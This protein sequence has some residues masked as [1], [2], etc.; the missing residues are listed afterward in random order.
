MADVN[1][2]KYKF[3]DSYSGVP[4]GIFNGAAGGYHFGGGWDA[5]TDRR[6]SKRAE[7]LQLFKDYV[8]TLT[9]NGIVPNQNSLNNFLGQASGFGLDASYGFDPY[10]AQQMMESAIAQGEQKK[11][12]IQAKN[13]QTKLENAKRIREDLK[14]LVGQ[15]GS[16]EDALKKRVSTRYEGWS[17]EEVNDYTA[18]ATQ[19]YLEDTSKNLNTL[20]GDSVDEDQFDELKKQYKGAPPAVLAAIDNKYNANVEAASNNIATNLAPTLANVTD[21]ET[22][23]KMVSAQAPE[24][25]KNN[26]QFIENTLKKIEGRS[27]NFKGQLHQS[28]AEDIAKN[29]HNINQKYAELKAAEEDKIRAAQAALEARQKSDAI[30]RSKNKEKEKEL[31]KGEKN[32]TKKA[33]AESKIDAKW[34]YDIHDAEI[35]EKI[36]NAEDISEVHQAIQEGLKNG[37]VFTQAELD[38]IEQRELLAK[39]KSKDF[40]T[41]DKGYDYKQ[42][43]RIRMPL[44][45]R[46]LGGLKTASDKRKG[47][48]LSDDFQLNKAAELIS[49]DIGEWRGIISYG[50]PHNYS[51]QELGTL[52]NQVATQML[53]QAGFSPDQIKTILAKA[54]KITTPVMDIPANLSEAERYRAAYLG[55]ANQ[56]GATY[57]GGYMPLGTNN[58][59]TNIGGTNVVTGGTN[60]YKQPTSVQGGA[61]S[62][63]GTPTRG[64]GQT[65]ASQSQMYGQSPV[66]QSIIDAHRQPSIAER[67]LRQ[68]QMSIP[69]TWRAFQDALQE[70]QRQLRKGVVTPES[71]AAYD[72][73]R[74]KDLDPSGSFRKHKP[75]PFYVEAMKVKDNKHWAQFHYNNE[76]VGRLASEAEYMNGLPTGAMRGIIAGEQTYSDETPLNQNS[77]AMGVAQMTT[78]TAKGRTRFGDL[79]HNRLNTAQNLDKS[80]QLMREC[81]EQANGDMVGAYLQYKSGTAARKQYLGLKRNHPN[82]SVEEILNNMIKDARGNG[83]ITGA[84]KAYIYRAISAMQNTSDDFLSYISS[85]QQFSLALGERDRKEKRFGQ[86][87]GQVIKDEYYDRYVANGGVPP[88]RPWWDWYGASNIGTANYSSSIEGIYPENTWKPSNEQEYKPF[89]WK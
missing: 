68:S 1:D 16:N 64:T 9:D 63:G 21:K 80:A 28:S 71:Q 23:R 24:A 8:Q 77:T 3:S 66:D 32:L 85:G 53:T 70:G 13:L 55:S 20:I 27:V 78:T 62:F 18:S 48:G 29:T 12:E 72:Y 79:A 4:T 87:I 41:A 5:E 60:F 58:G 67:L 46:I 82:W 31:Y 51:A 35:K 17:P 45:T 39:N 15:Y 81:Y 6:A 36:D 11:K 65:V 26:A 57:Y 83:Y 38:S 75:S 7:G 76:L 22:I 10:A 50:T 88:D 69:D 25:L 52:E 14:T 74:K 49:R 56:G 54:Q 61:Q 86:Y 44:E 37:T 59:T 2:T 30:A 33:L 19:E 84:E 43:A 34:D 47:V 40:W 42:I 73:Q 89:G